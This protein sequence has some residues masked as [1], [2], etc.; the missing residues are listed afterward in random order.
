MAENTDINLIS[1]WLNQLYRSKILLLN[2]YHPWYPHEWIPWYP[3]EPRSK[4]GHHWSIPPDRRKTRDCDIPHWGILWQS[5]SAWG[6]SPTS[7]TTT[8]KTAQKKRQGNRSHC[9]LSLEDSYGNYGNSKSGKWLCACTGG[10]GAWFS[11][12][13]LL[14]SCTS[15]I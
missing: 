11:L 9:F 7:C 3:A 8:K 1:A 4:R 14:V 13:L 2:L 10:A 6:D 15:G 5:M 12:L